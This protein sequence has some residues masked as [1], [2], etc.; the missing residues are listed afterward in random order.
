MNKSYK[1]HEISIT[2]YGSGYSLKISGPL[3]VS[4]AGT[5]TDT[6]SA[7]DY[8]I[9]KIDDAEADEAKPTPKPSV[10]S[11]QRELADM[12]ERAALYEQS[13]Q[14]HAQIREE[15]AETL[16]QVR[17]DLA[18]LL[19]YFAKDWLGPVAGNYRRLK[20]FVEGGNG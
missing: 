13:S 20:K 4:R 3:V 5:F 16:T 15:Q 7:L 6:K 19:D 11:L 18:P 12:T 9:A 10:A 1:D 17:A 14:E 2:P 8:A